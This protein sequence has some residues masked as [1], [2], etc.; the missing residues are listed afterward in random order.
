MS[1]PGVTLLNM[2]AVISGTAIAYIGTHGYTTDGSVLVKDTP[3]F[4]LP[5][6]GEST[7][8]EAE[9]GATSAN[10]YDTSLIVKNGDLI[11][12]VECWG[13]SGGGSDQHDGTTRYGGGSGSY[14]RADFTLTPG[15]YRIIVG[16]GGKTNRYANDAGMGGFGGAGGSGYRYLDGSYVYSSGQSGDPAGTGGN[17]NLSNPHVPFT[18]GSLQWAGGGGGLTG[19]FN[20]MTLSQANAL[21]I[22]AGG[23]GGGSESGGNGHGGDET[24]NS[25]GGGALFGTGGGAASTDARFGGGGGSGYTGGAGDYI[26]GG[27]GGISYIHGDGANSYFEAGAQGP[28]SAGVAP[29][30]DDQPNYIADFGL[31]TTANGKNGMMVLTLLS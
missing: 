30:G 29:G 19:L 14:N 11:V 5:K 15:E 10:G 31:S 2:P 22:S 20:T 9:I 6:D 13:A 27:K 28:T 26:R 24:S 1:F 16:S 7:N 3:F 12:T 18:G 21:I 17:S 8:P 23:G 4:F 25:G